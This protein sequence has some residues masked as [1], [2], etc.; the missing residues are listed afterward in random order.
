MNRAVF[1]GLIAAALALA[2]AFRLAGLDLRP[3]HHDEANQAVKFGRLLETGEY[4]YDPNDHH[5]PSLYYLTLPAAW[6]RG[7]TTLASLDELTLRSVPALFGAGLVLLLPL[8]AGLSRTAVLSAALLIAVSPALTYYSRDYIQESLFVFFTL[9]WMMMLGRY[10]LK[11]GSGWAVAAGSFAGL[12]YATKETA[13]IVVPATLVAAWM[14]LRWS[15]T[16]GAGRGTLAPLADRRRWRAAHL[17]AA[18][19]AAAIVAFVFL[20]SFLSRPAGLVESVLAFGTYAGRGVESGMHTQPWDYYLRLLAWS[21]SGRLVWSEGLVLGLALVGIAAS[22]RRAAG[23]WPRYVGWYAL[24]TTIAFSLLRYK[25]PWNVLPFYIGLVFMAG[26][27]V[28]TV[29]TLPHRR[30]ARGA[31]LAGLA[32]LTWQLGLQS[33]RANF[34]YPADP[35]NPYVYAQ[36]STDFLRLVTRIEDLAAVHPDGSAMFIRIVA[37]PYEQWPLPWYLRG[38]TRVGYWTSTDETGPVDD[39]PV[40]V[41]SEENTAAVAA[42]LDDRYVSEFYGLRPNTLLTVFIEQPLWDRFI[43]SRQAGSGP[44]PAMEGGRP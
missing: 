2:L 6:L 12:T 14:T 32:A 1:G 25:T 3:M 27:G 38:M 42:A 7:Q 36:T 23:F 11:P 29:V 44:A 24:I 33:W 5:G 10:L 17:A 9:G 41:A 31:L 30:I 13:V 22:W 37:G 21:R 4:E 15:G 35:R 40:V 34:V 26:V 18:L 8:A 39:A 43:R 28:H 16:A 19:G 20:S